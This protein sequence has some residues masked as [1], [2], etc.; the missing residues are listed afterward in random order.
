MSTR[1]TKY[2]DVGTLSTKD[3]HSRDGAITSLTHSALPL[4]SWTYHHDQPRNTLQMRPEVISETWQATQ[5]LL[6]FLPVCSVILYD[7]CKELRWS[8][9]GYKYS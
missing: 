6:R 8:M 7:H 5:P 2:S 1:L 4:N 3:P 9:S